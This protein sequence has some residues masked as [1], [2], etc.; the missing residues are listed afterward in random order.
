[1]P[2]R[3]LASAGTPV[4]YQIA[5]CRCGSLVLQVVFADREGTSAQVALQQTPQQS[6]NAQGT[7]KQALTTDLAQMQ[8]QDSQPNQQQQRQQQQ[9]Q[10]QEQLV[11]QPQKWNVMYC[12][13]HPRCSGMLTAE[14]VIAHTGDT[15]AIVWS[16]EQ[17]NAGMPTPGPSRMVHTKCWVGKMYVQGLLVCIVMRILAASSIATTT[18]E[19]SV[20]IAS[21]SM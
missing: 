1:M 16:L 21:T 13:W 3:H 19:D 8:L 7:S 17:G 9:Q 6:I 4:K 12:K 10:Q 5:W 20:L 18:S 2:S 11:I 15:S 14:A